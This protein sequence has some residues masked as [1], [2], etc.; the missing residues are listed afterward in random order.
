MIEV[1][2]ATDNGLFAITESDSNW[3]AQKEFLRDRSITSVA[4]WGS[5]IIA[6][7]R[8]GLLYSSDSGQSW[9]PTGIEAG[10]QHVRWLA[11]HSGKPY[12]ALAGSEP[13]AIHLSTDGGRTWRDSPGVAE[14]RDRLG[15]FLPYSPEAGCVRGFAS[16]E[17]LIYAAVEVGGLLFSRDNGE[18]WQLVAGSDGQPK[19]GSPPPDFIHPDV[20]SIEIHPSFPERL[21]APT[22]GGFYTSIDAGQSWQES[23]PPSYCRAVWVD[24]ANP[25]HL[26]L[27]PAR[28]VSSYGRIVESIDG[29]RNWNEIGSGLD[30]PWPRVMVERFLQAG[31]TLMAVL[32]DGQLLQAKVGKWHWQRILPEIGKVRALASDWKNKH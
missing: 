3:I 29:G 27:G 26:V 18:T 28:S 10:L 1:F 13:A 31:N 32:S 7:T 30:L 14:L 25:D 24:S 15:W 6:G 12:I 19:F 4:V 8:Q 5:R 20:H 21:Y 22:G 2:A 17:Q 11:Y 9:L 23:H 16:S